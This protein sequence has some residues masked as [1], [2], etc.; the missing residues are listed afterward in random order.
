MFL[1]LLSQV[2]FRGVIDTE[3]FTI[4]FIRL[5]PSSGRD[6][7]EQRLIWVI[8]VSIYR[9]DSISLFLS[10]APSLWVTNRKYLTQTF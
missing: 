8:S 2:F 6:R 5:F 1:N 10:L 7:K 9:F 3:A 4:V